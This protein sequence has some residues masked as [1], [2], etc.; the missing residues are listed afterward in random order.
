[1]SLSETHKRSIADSLVRGAGNIAER[2]SR[3]D[4][5][6]WDS[7][8]Q[9][10]LYGPEF[11]QRLSA[12]SNKIPYWSAY[13]FAQSNLPVAVHLLIPPKDALVL[14]QVLAT[15]YG[16]GESVKLFSPQDAVK[17]FANIAA[18][19]FCGEFGRLSRSIWILSTPE[20]SRGERNEIISNQWRSLKGAN[21]AFVSTITNTGFQFKMDYELGLYASEKA[22]E[23]YFP[24]ES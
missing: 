3:F 19:I 10:D 11:L 16:K 1:M 24:R 22:L 13:L 15:A 23:S 9:T 4:G 7:K 8:V 14:S 18:H 2:L 17:E 20:I 5:H 12:E 6:P 21:I